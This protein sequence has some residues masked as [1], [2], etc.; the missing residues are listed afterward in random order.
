MNKTALEN[1]ILVCEECGEEFAFT[2]AAQQ[3]FLEK[4]YLQSPKRCKFCHGK[5]KREKKPVRA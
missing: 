1:R 4:G 2:V 3:Y 5:Y